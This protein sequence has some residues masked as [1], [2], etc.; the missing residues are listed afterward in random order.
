MLSQARFLDVMAATP[1]PVTVVTTASPSEPVGSTVSAF[2]SLSLDPM[3]VV[4]AL[5][6]RSRVLP[7]IESTR[8]FGVNVLAAGQTEAALAFAR[9]GADKFADADW[10]MDRGLPRLQRTACWLACDLDDVVAGGDHKMLVGAVTDAAC[11]PLAPL[12]YSHRLFGIHS[13]AGQRFRTPMEAHV[14][15]LGQY[16][17]PPLKPLAARAYPTQEHRDA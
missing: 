2:M 11:A 10:E 15:A 1:A 3:L 7:V 6:N 14:A 16:E 4:V 8:T 17:P 5:D 12:V 13:K 9:S